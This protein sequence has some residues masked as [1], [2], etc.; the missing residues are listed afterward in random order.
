ME[1]A[2][3]HFNLSPY[4]FTGVFEALGKFADILMTVFLLFVLAILFFAPLLNGDEAR[5]RYGGRP[6]KAQPRKNE[7]RLVS[8]EFLAVLLL[9][10]IMSLVFYYVPSLR[11][12]II[13]LVVII[14][15]T[16]L[17]LWLIARKSQ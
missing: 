11:E 6:T 5:Y 13:L 8:R 9:L 15:P 2:P 4:L 16:G 14:V 17:I 7:I 10:L 12:I 1:P 3:F